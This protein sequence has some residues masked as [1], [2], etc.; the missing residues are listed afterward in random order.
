MR[1]VAIAI[2][3]EWNVVR[4]IDDNQFSAPL[5]PMIPERC[6]RS[7]VNMSRRRGQGCR[8]ALRLSKP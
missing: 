3:T 5:G 6:W 8:N 7:G 1:R 4:L 2:P